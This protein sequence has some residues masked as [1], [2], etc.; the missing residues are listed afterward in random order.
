MT[1]MP[2]SEIVYTDDVSRVTAAALTGFFVG[3]P[4]PPA[5]A[6]HLAILQGS[7]A[8]WLA[9]DGARCVGFVNALSDGVFYAYIPLLEVL[10]AYQGRGI[11]SELMRRMV[12]TMSEMYAIDVLC[13]AEVAPFYAR[14][15]FKQGVGMFHR[16]YTK[17]DAAHYAD[18]LGKSA[19]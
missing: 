4:N 16:N 18:K 15:G 14:L 7:A 10:P 13:D 17:Q 1:R 5:P 3:W 8:V 19:D 11:G 9:L 12:R 6:T 2:P